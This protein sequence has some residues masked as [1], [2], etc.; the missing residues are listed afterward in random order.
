MDF[1]IKK[2]LLTFRVAGDFDLSLCPPLKEKMLKAIEMDGVNRII[3]DM[4]EVTFLDSSAL[5]LILTAYKK[6]APLGG[7]VGIINLQPKLRQLFEMAGLEHIIK[8]SLTKEVQ[9]D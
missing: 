6:T 9:D 5:G 3:F 2:N 8:I 1:Q 4:K 7:G